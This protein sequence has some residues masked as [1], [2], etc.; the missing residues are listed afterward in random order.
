MFTSRVATT[1]TIAPTSSAL[2]GVRKRGE[3]WLTVLEQGVPAPRARARPYVL[4]GL[5]SGVIR[6]L[7]AVEHVDVGRD[8]HRCSAEQPVAAGVSPEAVRRDMRGAMGGQEE[9]QSVVEAGDEQ[10]QEDTE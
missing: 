2:T 3:A 5:L 9:T 6:L 8:S 4:L 1:G 10:D 7:E